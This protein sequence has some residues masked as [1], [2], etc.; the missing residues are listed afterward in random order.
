MNHSAPQ[1]ALVV[2]PKMPWDV[3]DPC[4]AE[5]Q[6][7]ALRD[8]LDAER[9]DRDLAVE[10]STQVARAQ[11]L[12][13]RLDDATHTLDA[14]ARRLGAS[15]AVEPRLRLLLERG[16]LQV[17]RKIPSV[18]HVRFLEAYSLATEAGADYHAADAAQMIA[19]VESRAAKLPWIM[20]ALALAEASSDERT[21]AW[22]GPLHSTLGTHYVERLRLSEALTHFERSAEF[23]DTGG[24]TR[25]AI[26]ARCDSARVLRMMQRTDEALVLQRRL[27][28]EL[29]RRGEADGVVLEEI[30]ECLSS[31]DRNDEASVF[32][33]RAYDLLSSDVWLTN[34]QPERIRRL[35]TLGKRPK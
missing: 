17:M 14:A 23:F 19:A 24:A 21:K 27:E 7:L 10:I 11:S 12:Q 8:S 34:N 9:A 33:G 29:A 16:R 28:A 35:K 22:L 6:L 30:G 18:A 15:G 25:A 2:D 31:Q 5:K 1:P 3:F 26:T 32:F 13:G 20:R 4:A